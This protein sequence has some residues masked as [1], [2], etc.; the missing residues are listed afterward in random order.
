MPRVHREL[1]S[2]AAT[3]YYHCISRCVRRESQD[4]ESQDTHRKIDLSPF[5]FFSLFLALLAELRRTY[6]SARRIVLIVDNY[7]IHR[8]RRTLRWLAQNPKFELLFQPVYHPW[9]NRIERLWKQL[10]DTI[11]RNH[12]HPTMEA[13]PTTASPSPTCATSSP[14]CPRPRPSRQSRRCCRG[15]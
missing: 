5:S 3:P 9:V 7:I 10:H 4:T 8:S 2:L 14:S 15:T 6:R 11:T 13:R 12:R 1:V